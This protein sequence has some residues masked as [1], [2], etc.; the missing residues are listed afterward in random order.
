MLNELDKELEK[1]GLKFVRYAD[2]SI[3]MTKSEMSARRIMRNVTKFIEEKLGLIV[4]AEKSQI[5][6]P[7]NLKFLGFGFYYSPSKKTHRARPHEASIEKFKY[8]L[9][10]L[11]KRSWGIS[12]D[13]RIKRINQTVRGWVNYFKQC[14]MKKVLKKISEHLRYRLRKCI[15]KQWKRGKTRVKA[16]RKLGMTSYNA[17]RNGHSSKSYAR[18]AMS[19]V[20]TT[21]VTNARLKQKG[22]VSPLD[23]YL[24]VHA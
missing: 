1:R 8:K 21:T 23:H 9:K 17:H 13:A 10:E 12:M 5:T 2:D 20:M 4:N 6:K 7:S 15:W 18:I 22:L 19:W 16:L 11:S 24:K 14:D 3:I